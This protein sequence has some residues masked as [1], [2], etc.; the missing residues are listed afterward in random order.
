MKNDAIFVRMRS[1]DSSLEYRK[2]VD[3]KGTCGSVEFQLNFISIANLENP[4]Q[5]FSQ[6]DR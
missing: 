5:R 6:N 4:E 3:Q 2:N 1:G